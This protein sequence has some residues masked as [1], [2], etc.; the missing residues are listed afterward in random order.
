MKTKLFQ[1]FVSTGFVVSLFWVALPV[2][3]EVAQTQAP[4][5]IIP[6]SEQGFVHFMDMTVSPTEVNAGETVT[7]TVNITNSSPLLEN[8]NIILMINDVAEETKT[9]YLDGFESRSVPFTTV[10]NT[11]GTYRVSFS[12]LS[13]TF[14]VKNTAVTTVPAVTTGPAVPAVL[15]PA[16]QVNWMFTGGI[17]AVVTIIIGSIIWWLTL[18]PRA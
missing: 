12:N 11:A 2:S 15:P 6:F 3:A 7:I 1:V 5:S 4:L 17:I 9:V 18:R 16:K 8:Y 10:K 13:A 14:K